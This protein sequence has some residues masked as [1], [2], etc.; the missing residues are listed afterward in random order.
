MA[1][2]YQNISADEMEEFMVELGLAQAEPGHP[3]NETVYEMPYGEGFRV[4]VYS[5]I[6]HGS[7]RKASCASMRRGRDSTAPH[8]FIEPRTGARTS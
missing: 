7:G 6:A 8:V 1:A 5:T 3:C 4:R 2:E